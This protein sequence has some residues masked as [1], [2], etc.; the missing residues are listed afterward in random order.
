MAGDRAGIHEEKDKGQN[1][2][3]KLNRDGVQ[4]FGRGDFPQ[5]IIAFTNA[6][7]MLEEAPV[8][9]SEDDVS[10]KARARELAVTLVNRARAQLGAGDALQAEKDATQASSID[11]SYGRAKTVLAEAYQKQGRTK[12]AEALLKEPRPPSMHL[13]RLP[14]LLHAASWRALAAYAVLATLLVSVLALHRRLALD[15]LHGRQP[16]LGAEELREVLRYSS[17]YG[18]GSFPARIRPERVEDAQRA[19]KTTSA[20]EWSTFMNQ[21]FGRQIPQEDGKL[22][23]FSWGE[24][25]PKQGK[26]GKEVAGAPWIGMLAF[27][28]KEANPLKLVQLVPERAAFGRLKRLGHSARSFLQKQFG[29]GSASGGLLPLALLVQGTVADEQRLPQQL[30]FARLSLLVV[31]VIALAIA[32]GVYVAVVSLRNFRRH[33]AMTELFDPNGRFIIGLEKDLAEEAPELKP[34]ALD[35]G[36][37]IITMN[38]FIY[39]PEKFTFFSRLFQP[40]LLLTNLVGIGSGQEPKPPSVG[41]I[42]HRCFQVVG[43]IPSWL[44]LLRRSLPGAVQVSPLW[45]LQLGFR[46]D[47]GTPP[48]GQVILWDAS[49]GHFADIIGDQK[50]MENLGRDIATRQAVATK[51]ITSAAISETGGIQKAEGG[52]DPRSMS[53][54][55]CYEVLKLS[56][57]DVRAAQST[58]KEEAKSRLARAFRLRVME[59]LDAEKRQVEEVGLALDV[60]MRRI[61]LSLEM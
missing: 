30:T 25:T 20:Q 26:G 17:G 18:V 42:L 8:V 34:R 11:S 28:P 9:C 16:V 4:A 1:E 37:V 55:R 32:Y 23:L 45:E 22:L 33:P 19:L 38:W 50:E 53:L 43:L 48:R 58:S 46:S 24:K 2:A 6:F 59:D 31:L 47:Q 14:A 60:L 3:A 5:A 44:H 36:K 54:E 21:A 13:T 15:A 39:L 40:L 35:D 51:L 7:R 29:L 10:S 41:G 57:D 52:P 56:R 49:R 61:S 12:D 27:V